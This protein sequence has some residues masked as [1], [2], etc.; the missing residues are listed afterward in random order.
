MDRLF[1]W[2]GLAALGVSLTGCVSTQKYDAMVHQRDLATAKAEQAERNASQARL[3]ANQSHQQL[4][5]VMED[6]QG[7]I[8]ELSNQNAT[9]QSQLQDMNARYT[10]A[11]DAPHTGDK[12][13]AALTSAIK[14]FATDNKET[15]EFD[16]TRGVL[17]FKSDVTF[18]PGSAEVTAKTKGVIEQLAKILGSD[19]FKPY[20]LMVAGHTDNVPVSR[21][22]TVKKGHLDNWYLSSHRAI[23][24]AELLQKMHIAPNRISVTGYADQQPVASNDTAAGRAQNRRVE[25]LILPT[26]AKPA[27]AKAGATTRP[28]ASKT[29][30]TSHRSS[31]AVDQGPVFNK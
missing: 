15:V 16:A 20:E 30:H 23:A 18:A 26:I 8:S 10:E 24:V 6:S 17:K 21:N 22:A 2:A 31:A 11:M 5:A 19:G 1:H 12:L 29:A 13:P 9:L 4:G 3:E 25:V 14:T 7:R 27:V 28:V